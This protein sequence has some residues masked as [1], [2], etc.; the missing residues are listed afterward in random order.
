MT[1]STPNADPARSA[2]DESAPPA[3]GFVGLAEL[4]ELAELAHALAAELARR[5]AR[6]QRAVKAGTAPAGLRAAATLPPPTRPT[7]S[8]TS[9]GA[10]P[11]GAVAQ[12]PPPTAAI[13]RAA[14]NLDELRAA[15]AECRA[16]PLCEERSQ[17]VF[18]DGSPRARILFV[19]AA[20]GAQE[21]Q[22][23]VPFVDAAG[24]LLDDIIAKGMGL[25]R[26]RDVYLATAVKCRPPHDRDPAP[27]EK[28]MCAPFLAR[29][30]ELV[31][32]RVVV[33]LGDHAA[34]L[35]L[36]V[37]APVGALRG[38]VHRLGGR[39]VVPT[40]HPAL[41]LQNPAAKRETWVDI[42]LAM[43]ELGL[44][45]PGPAQGDGAKP[46]DGPKPGGRSTAE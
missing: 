30:I 25:A 9:A 29:Q 24:Q 46:S 34:A 31:D 42:R 32:P 2:A 33:T 11:K 1:E 15:V 38:R 27:A 39:A 37:D 19:G 4:A 7:R 26:H 20:P 21:D 18:S 40:H 6:G 3:P 12:A 17:T 36:D 8:N 43:A 35:V 28:A 16:C 22:D 5:G 45:L 44:A 13:A 10:G 23:G 14:Q 41:L